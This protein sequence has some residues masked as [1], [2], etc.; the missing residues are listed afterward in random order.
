MTDR[1]ILGNPFMCLLYPFITDSEGITTH[2]FGQPVKFKFLR[3]PEPKEISNLQN[4]SVSKTLNPLTAK[5][6]KRCKQAQNLDTF[7]S[8]TS[9]SAVEISGPN[10]SQISSHHIYHKNIDS[11]PSHVFNCIFEKKIH[12]TPLNMFWQENRISPISA[13]K[14]ASSKNKEKAPMKGFSQDE[15]LPPMGQSFKMH[16]GT[17]FGSEP[18]RVASLQQITYSDGTMAITL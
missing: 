13:W 15:R 2:P 4:V 10:Q 5:I 11:T 14:M 12:Y 8:T 18:R 17:S 3:S 7:A 6:H 9:C 16:E 1:V